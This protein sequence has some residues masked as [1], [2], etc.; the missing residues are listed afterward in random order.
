MTATELEGVARFAAFIAERH[1]IY[2][3]R[4]AGQP[5]PW[6]DDPIL[7]QY[8]FCNVFRNLDTQTQLIQQNWLEKRPP[9]PDAWFAMVVAR[10]VNWWPSL[11][12]VGYPVPW[13]PKQFVKAMD[14]R[15][16]AGEKV[17]TG[18]Y[19]VHADATHSGT[20]AAYLAEMVLTPM[21]KDRARLRPV[22]GDT[23]DGFHRRLM[24]YRDMGSFM[25]AQVVADAKYD[26]HSPLNKAEDFGTWAASGPGSRRGLNRVLGR[27][28]DTPWKEGD[29]RTEFAKVLDPF[30][31][32]LRQHGLT[33][34]TGQD[35]QS[36]YCEYDKYERVRLGEGRPRSLYHP[37]KAN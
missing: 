18:A 5:W 14:D 10:L 3:R 7:R 20:K 1:A 32:Q 33:P 21:W 37:P 31:Q 22:E 12:A 27:D 23:L 4:K 29:W 28:Y 26:I 17:F 25:A 35:A 8:R 2:V 13:K 24:E 36:A 34:L 9:D 6:T 11:E 19:M 15:R 30:N 16:A